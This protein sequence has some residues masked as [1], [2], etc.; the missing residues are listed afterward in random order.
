MLQLDEIETQV[1]YLL[2]RSDQV[3]TS[4]AELATTNFVFRRFVALLP[5]EDYTRIDTSLSTT[6]G[7]ETYLWPSNPNF[8]DVLS[9]EIQDG[10]D[11]EKYKRVVP[12]RSIQ[13]WL[14]LESAPQDTPTTYRLYRALATDAVTLAL[15]PIP[16]YSTKTIRIDGI[17]EPP[18]FTSGIE[19]TGFRLAGIDDAFAMAL[20]GVFASKLG[21][22]ARAAEMLQWSS[23]TIRLNT[24][25]EISPDEM[26]EK[27]VL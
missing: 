11:A 21:E 6:A 9:M 25:K 5:W 18:S 22:S 3:I 16:K 10:A 27:L 17:I 19:R 14:A 20:T 2:R 8:Q 13:A 12:A 23:N 1:Q 24:G 26:R 7:T 15:R 4:G